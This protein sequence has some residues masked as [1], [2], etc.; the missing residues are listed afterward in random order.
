KR[1][2][3]FPQP[4]VAWRNVHVGRNISHA[5]LLTDSHSVCG[6]CQSIDA[7]RFVY[8]DA[9]IIHEH[10]GS[11]TKT[12]ILVPRWKVASRKI[13]TRWK[14]R[15]ILADHRRSNEQD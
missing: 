2:P 10:A 14:R 11:S 12:N 4:E 15:N 6:P 5:L 3:I 1:I 9:A 7:P 13:N 8:R